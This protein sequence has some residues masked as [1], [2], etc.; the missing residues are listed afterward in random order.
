MW[1]YILLAASATAFILAVRQRVY[2]KPYPGIPYNE[3]SAHRISG[4]LPE[5]VPVI[6]STNEYSTAIFS[7]TTQRLGKPIAQMLFPALRKPLIIL[8]DPREIEDI[9]VRRNREFD[10]APMAINTLRPMFANATTSQYT[11]PQLRAQKRLWADVMSAEF[12]HKAA[13]PNIYKATLNLLELWRLKAS[14]SVH[15]DQPFK[16]PEDFQNA[17]LDAMWVAV[18]GEEPGVTRYEITKLQNQIAGTSENNIPPPRGIFLKR[19]V[20]YI[21]DV[22]AKNASSPVPGWAQKLETYMPRHR[23]F[24]RTVNAE[25]TLVMGKAVDRFQRLDLGKLEAEEMDTCM[26][27]LVLRRLVLAAKKAQQP[28]ADPTKDQHMLDEM[29]LLLVAG[30]DSTANLLTWFV[31]YMESY[32]IAQSE[33]RAALKAAFPNSKVPAMEDIIGKNIPYLDAAC[34][35]T[36]RLGGVAKGNLRQALV[37]TEVLGCKIP[38]GAEIFMN[39]HF[40]HA[41]YPVNESDRSA[42]SQTAGAKYGDDRLYGSAGHDLGNFEPK[43]W[44]VKD[45]QTEREVFNPYALPSLAFGGGYRGC[46]GRKLAVME[47]RLIVVLLVLNFEFLELP[48][49]LKTLKASEKVFRSPDMPFV[50]LQALS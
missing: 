3:Q 26:S 21:A 6:K 18:V 24:R 25:I 41:P 27:D 9:L 35:E 44:L 49:N 16:V 38:K 34:E 8:E 33:L 10:K 22:I 4:D 31:R 29:F 5:L 17:T 15:K 43:R 36:F 23:Q 40:N 37:D 47:F 7:I 50:R 39:Y 2:P 11:T 19:E 32:P 45:A 46:S 42:S 1:L 48:D 13:A 20:D 28:L 12:L 14:S 30:Y